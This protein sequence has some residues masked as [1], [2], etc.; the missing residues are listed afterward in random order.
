MTADEKRIAE[1]L[2]A[3]AAVCRS[4][5]PPG[6]KT[7]EYTAGLLAGEFSPHAFTRQS[8]QAVAGQCDFFPSFAVLKTALTEWATTQTRHREIGAP[9]PTIPDWLFEKIMANVG[10][11]P[12]PW[13]AAWLRGK[14]RYV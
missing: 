13:L 12:G 10:D 1:W 6:V 3:L 4:G 2:T 11:Q 5:S 7:I 8:L 14:G 9:D